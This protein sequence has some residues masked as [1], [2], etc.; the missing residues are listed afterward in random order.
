VQ[1]ECGRLPRSRT[2]GRPVRPGPAG[3]P[4]G[5][6]PNKRLGRWVFER[7]KEPPARQGLALCSITGD[8]ETPGAA[9]MDCSGPRW[10]AGPRRSFDDIPRQLLP[11]VSLT[12]L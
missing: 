1:S 2:P 4:D 12:V 10:I 3:R 11:K 8:A 7:V 5:Q 9:E 6:P